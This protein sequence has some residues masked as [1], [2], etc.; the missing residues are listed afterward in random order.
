MSHC[1]LVFLFLIGFTGCT[2]TVDP[3]SAA[4]LLTHLSDTQTT[5]A[6]VPDPLLYLRTLR[7]ELEKLGDMPMDHA[8]RNDT[9]ACVETARRDFCGSHLEQKLKAEASDFKIE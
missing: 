8:C 2:K 9:K 7:P 3:W 4:T 6:C 1:S 5:I